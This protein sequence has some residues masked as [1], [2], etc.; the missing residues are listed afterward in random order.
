MFL[1]FHPGRLTLKNKLALPETWRHF[2]TGGLVITQGI[3]RNLLILPHAAFEEIY[4]SV[5]SLNMTD[6]TARLFSRLLLGRAFTS[7][8]DS[9]G[10]ISLPEEL[11]KY[12]G[13]Q[14]EM[15]FIGQGKYMEVWNSAGWQDQLSALEDPQ[16]NSARFASLTIAAN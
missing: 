14:E 6:P 7:A 16:A 8:L 3:D 2:I 13:L 11:I 5:A 9:K 1:G 10:R 4:Q 15:I 12:A